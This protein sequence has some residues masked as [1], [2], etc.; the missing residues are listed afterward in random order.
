[1]W[2]E[3]SRDLL[4]GGVGWEFGE[5]LWSPTHKN[6]RGTWP[7]WE[8]LRQIKEGDLV[9]HLRGKGKRAAFVGFSSADSAGY[10]AN[11]RPPDPAQWSYA[12]AFYRVPLTNYTPFVDPIPLTS[13]L[14]AQDA[15]LRKYL[16]NN[17][18]LPR[19][20]RRHLFYVVQSGR[21]QCLNGA[22][23]SEVDAELAELLFGRDVIGNQNASRPISVTVRTGEQLAQCRRRIGQKDFSIQVRANYEERC[24][25][26]GCTIGEPELLVGSH[27]ARWADAAAL[28]GLA[29]NGLC[30]CLFHDKA[31]EYGMFTL[32]L[33]HRISINHERAK[34][35]PWA[36]QNLSPH[37]NEAIRPGLAKP[38]TESIRKHWERIGFIPS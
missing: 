20:Q 14:I 16:L 15:S 13:V 12:A 10:I 19:L 2:L 38:S 35:S 25:F 28:R 33:D 9:F 37:G 34:K 29:S 18:S 30:L 3:M 11:H 7:Y 31:F 17:R 22:Y 5:C 1:M 6:P 21:L 26:P 8:T 27:I 23:L 24:C 4:H 36:Q 32:T